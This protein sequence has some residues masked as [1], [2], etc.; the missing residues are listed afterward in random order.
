MDRA[1]T[2]RPSTSTPAGAPSAAGSARSF[3]YRSTTVAVYVSVWPTAS[4]V[5]RRPMRVRAA[6]PGR[7]VYVTEST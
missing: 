7:T 3:P 2:F 4:V 6:A 5:S 1:V